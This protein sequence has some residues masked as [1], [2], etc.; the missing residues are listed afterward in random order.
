MVRGFIDVRDHGDCFSS[1]S[2]QLRKAYGLRVVLNAGR[3][4]AATSAPWE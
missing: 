4:N 2:P 3:L 1:Q